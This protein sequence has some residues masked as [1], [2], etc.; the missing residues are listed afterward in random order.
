MSTD[1]VALI[2]TPPSGRSR[3]VLLDGDDYAQAVLLQGRDVPTAEPMA[4]AN[5]V[6][7]VQDL[8]EP[9]AALL[10]LGPLYAARVATDTGLRTAMGSKSRTGFALRSLLADAALTARAIELVTLVT[11]TQHRPVV[12]QVPSPRM[13][14]TTTH[15]FS[16]DANTDGLDSD[17]AENASMYVADWLRN[18]ASLPLAA[19][20][21]D[22]RP[23][24]TAPTPTVVP[25]QVY[26]PVANT[27]THYRWT[28][29]MRHTTRVELHGSDLTGGVVPTEYWLDDGVAL[30]EG[31]FLL[32]EIPPTAVPEGVLKRVA[33]IGY[34]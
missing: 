19:V 21:L 3:S 18:F 29:A 8:L 27:T 20:L 2:T 12:L 13:W 16:G 32:G 1:L 25:L 33:T 4:F 15:H 22:D 14:L 34:A 10:S 31:D 28:L 24:Q 23:T 26:S 7:Q 5:H 11:R 30:P 6:R 9:D 17:D